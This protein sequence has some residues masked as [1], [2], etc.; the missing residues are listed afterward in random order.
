MTTVSAPSLH[1]RRPRRT[2]GRDERGYVMAL[3]ALLMIPLL[4][5]TAFAV[6]LGAW[7]AQANR[8]Q[9]A[10]D[11]SALAGVVWAADYQNPNKWDTIARDTA[12]KNSY[13]DGTNGVTVTTQKINQARIKVTICAD[14]Q[15]FFSQLVFR[16]ER[17]CRSATAEYVL[18]VP[19][20]SPRNYIGTGGLGR[21]TDATSVYAPERLWMAVSGYCTDRV[22]GDQVA[23]RYFNSPSSPNNGCTGTQNTDFSDENYQY[24][25]DLPAGRTYNTD[26][27][28]FNGNFVDNGGSC[29]SGGYAGT[30]NPNEF[31][32][33]GLAGK[34]SMSTTFSL[35]QADGTP[36]DDTDNPAMSAISTSNP[37][38]GCGSTTA[39]VNGIKT[40]APVANNP[41]DS[42]YDF[43]PSAANFT[44]TGNTTNSGW[45]RICTIPS[46]APP[47]RY[48]MRVRNQAAVAG[49]P[50]QANGSNAYSIVATPSTS[51]RLCNARTDTTCP[52][53][54]A[55]DYMSVYA[56]ANGSANFFLAEIGPEH[57]GK[58]V[59]INLWDSAEGA[60]EL[61]I[62]KP[63]GTNTWADQTFS[64]TSQCGP[65]ATAG[66]SGTNVTSIS[67]PSFNGCLLQITFTLTGY[68]PPADN[69][70]WR[71]YYVYGSNA[72]DRT[73][74]SVSITGDPVHLI[75]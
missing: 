43:N 34:P 44:D 55:T 30:N 66:A 36:L 62:K 1:R 57:A 14:G 60:T 32:P 24:Y 23:S 46:S 40:F 69:R 11:A 45:W 26:V 58:K 6:D 4:V 39:G 27:I 65:S 47:G 22:Q 68:S 71:V 18:P 19:L 61:R 28:I 31:C 2:R 25:I 8:I 10:A 20:G 33:G 56:L 70:W 7:Y 54:Y 48:I 37:S 64:Y 50:A 42:N 75:Q 15:Q 21:S 73:T 5:M 38:Q 29:S 16:G 52:K 63:T 17:L 41:G 51:Q 67:N 35:Y 59:T 9:R 3:F 13:T 49:A 12:T 53:V 74:W 72:T